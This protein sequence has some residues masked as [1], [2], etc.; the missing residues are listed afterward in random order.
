[1]GKHSLLYLKVNR[2]MVMEGVGFPWLR[3]KESACSAGDSGSMS[4]LER[5]PGGENGKP[6]QY[7]CPRKPVGQRSLGVTVHRVA[8]VRHDLATKQLQKIP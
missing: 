6:L 4:G 5:S 7:F 3:G 2:L 1:M 8:R